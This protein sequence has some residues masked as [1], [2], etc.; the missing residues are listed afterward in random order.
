MW[1]PTDQPG[2]LAAEAGVFT[3]LG[4]DVTRAVVCTGGWLRG[5]IVRA[6]GDHP[7]PVELTH[8]LQ[9]ALNRSS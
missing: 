8:T 1:A 3:E 9:R 4:L 7:D 6:S 5:R 2:L